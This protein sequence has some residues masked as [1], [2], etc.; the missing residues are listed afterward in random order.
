M[1]KI[2][3]SLLLEVTRRPEWRA[4]LRRNYKTSAEVW[5]VFNKKLSGRPRVAYNDAVEEALAFGWIDSITKKLDEDRF[6]Q[7]FTPR[8]PGSPYSESNLARLRAMAAKGKVVPGILANVRPLLAEKPVVVPP[9]ILAVIK[10][11]RETWKNFRAFSDSYK[12]IRIG[13]I[14]GARGRPGE[15]AKRLRHFLRMTKANRIIGFGGIQ[16]HY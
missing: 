4:W 1:P 3:R 13:Y 10:A 5:L 11:D 15:F 12:R 6:A 2:D 14:D 8:R 16:K 7:R 9:D